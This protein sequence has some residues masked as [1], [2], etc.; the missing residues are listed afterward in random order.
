MNQD[1]TQI[2]EE[3]GLKI[4]WLAQNQE[5]QEDAQTLSPENNTGWEI[6]NEEKEVFP[7]EAS[8]PQESISQESEEPFTPNLKEQGFMQIEQLLNWGNITE[9]QAEEFFL[10]ISSWEIEMVLKELQ[11]A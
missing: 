1:D 4:S 5:F 7:Q 6:E 2:Q 11:S 8:L 10:R 3:T 9:T